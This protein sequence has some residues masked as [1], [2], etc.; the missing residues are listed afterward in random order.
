MAVFSRRLN[1]TNT[2]IPQNNSD[3]NVRKLNEGGEKWLF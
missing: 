1:G 2:Q 3:I